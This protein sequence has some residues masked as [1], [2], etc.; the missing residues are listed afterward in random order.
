MRAG[1]VKNNEQFVIGFGDGGP[2]CFVKVDDVRL[3]HFIDRRIGVDADLLAT[4][5]AL[6]A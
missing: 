1:N 6:A 3:C 4:F 2:P 5:M